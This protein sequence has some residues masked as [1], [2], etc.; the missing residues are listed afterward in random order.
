MANYS[1]GR[2]SLLVLSFILL[3]ITPCSGKTKRTIIISQKGVGEK[4][5]V[6][7]LEQLIH[8]DINRVRKKYNLPIFKWTFDVAKVARKHSKDMGTKN[9]FA[10]ENKKGKLVADRLKVARVSFRACGENIFKCLNC[11]DVVKKAVLEWM[12]SPGHRA[13]ILNKTFTE[14]GVGIYKHPDNNEYYVTQN[15]IKRALTLI[16]KPKEISDEEIQKIFSLVQEAIAEKKWSSLSS[17]EK[18]IRKNLKKQRYTVK[19]TVTI[20]GFL[21]NRLVAELKVDLVVNEG[22]IINF[23]E[24]KIEAEKEIFT[25]FVNSQGYTAVILIQLDQQEIHYAILQAKEK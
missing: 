15:F 17:L 24:K 14:A 11:P 8:Q 25:P 5:S 12:D 4:R 6:S 2:I 13:N 1:K 3:A 18:K 21:K 23:T 19:R 16:P 9:Y 22:V 7:T 10:H 20:K